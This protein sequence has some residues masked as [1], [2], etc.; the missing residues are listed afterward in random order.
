MPVV[1]RNDIKSNSDQIYFGNS[2]FKIKGLTSG[3]SGSPLTVYRSPLS[4][5]IESAYISYFRKIH[6]F[7]TGD[8]LVSIRGVLDKNSL[9]KFC[10]YSN[11]LYISSP[12]INSKNIDLFHSLISRFKPKAIE[13]FP[14]YLFKLQVELAKKKL[15]IQIPLSFTSSEMLY[16]F[17]REQIE[18]YLNTKIFDWYGNVERTI[19]LVQYKYKTY[20][21]LPLYSIN[22]FNHDNVITTSL[23]NNFFPL[24]RYVVEDHIEVKSD[25]FIQNILAPEIIKINGRSGDTIDLKDGSQVSCIDHVF[26]GV[27][28][29]ELA[30]IHQNELIDT[31]LVKL[32][33]EPDFSMHDEEVLKG[34]F[35]KLIG[36]NMQLI[37]KYCN[38]A[39]LM[40]D[41]HLKF[42]LIVKQ[43][44]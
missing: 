2:F 31:L 36:N 39:E 6:G 21:P 42:K 28:H 17:Q 4:V 19:G 43:R 22:E 14:S 23:N 9:Y 10:K 41:S 8:P 1:Q 13:A 26:K 35:Q 12:N 40:S 29:L 7:K 20:Q 5:N 18:S 37:F 34:N 3:T 33:V 25:S 16:D 38:K 44:Q 32:V 15:S 24:I 27:S 11:V 30:Q